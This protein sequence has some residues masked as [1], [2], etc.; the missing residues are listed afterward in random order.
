MKHITHDPK[1][2]RAETATTIAANEEFVATGVRKDQFITMLG[3][4]LRHPLTPITHA[5]YLLR[6]SHQDPATIELLDT[7][8]AQTQTLV[9]FVNELLDLSR[10]SRGV[11]EI[12]PE[13]LDFAAV[14][15]DAVHVLQ[16]FIEQRRHVVSLVLPAA[17]YV[18]GDSSRL[19]QIVTN[20]VE[21]AAKY[22]D[23]GG[24]ITITLEQLGGEAV[25]AVRD[26]GIG[27][28]AEDLERIFEPFRLSHQPLVSPSCGLGIGL[29]MV[30]RIAELHGG[31]VKATSSQAGS[32]FVVS[33]PVAAAEI[34]GDGVFENVG[35]ISPPFVA[36]RAR[37]VM[38]VD[39][40]EE[41]RMSLTRLVRG[42][43][44]EAAVA[45]DGSSA[46][47]LAETFQPECAIVDISMPGMNG[48]EL[49]RR[50]RQRFPPATLRLIAFTGY[51]DADLR[52]AC[53]AAGFDAYVV[54]PGAIPELE[55]LLGGDRPDSDA[56]KHGP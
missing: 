26:N 32:E 23:P 17:L 21:N 3:H 38:I 42:W 31:R 40:H 14:V 9:R 6:K 10:I 33:L 8:D 45:A 11:I 28:A 41:I 22:T 13:L 39:D 27:I 29:S 50:L 36:L 5:M 1:A 49:C 43:G 37:R 34:P 19:L 51:A 16:P 18:R 56:S 46:L 2:Q 12:T 7:I 20:L 53:L 54:K 44:H 30:R 25:L 52:D 35:K 24:K 15:R 55:Q 4:E 48:W 47:S